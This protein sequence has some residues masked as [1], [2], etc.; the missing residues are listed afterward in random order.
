MRSEY[1]RND[2]RKKD[3]LWLIQCHVDSHCCTVKF[4]QVKCSSWVIITFVLVLT[5]VDG[6]DAS[7]SIL[8]LRT[9]RTL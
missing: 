1:D 9:G 4:K 2:K 8:I 5:D 6:F 3:Y 7:A